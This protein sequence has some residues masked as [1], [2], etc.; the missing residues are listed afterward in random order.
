MGRGRLGNCIF[1]RHFPADSN[2]EPAIEHIELINFLMLDY[3]G[4]GMLDSKDIPI[5][6]FALCSAINISS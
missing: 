1:Q 3:V 2:D 4:M 6:P 5:P